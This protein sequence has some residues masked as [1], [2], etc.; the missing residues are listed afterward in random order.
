MDAEDHGV[1]LR[2]AHADQG[3]VQQ[4]TYASV[5]LVV[6]CISLSYLYCNQIN[7]AVVVSFKWASA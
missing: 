2:G 1:R 7:K 5:T 3:G 4:L 6:L